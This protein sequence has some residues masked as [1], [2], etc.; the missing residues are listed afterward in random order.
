MPPRPGPDIK[1]IP[2]V[3]QPKPPR[4]HPIHI[5]GTPLPSVHHKPV[6]PPP[7]AKI[8]EEPQAK[9]SRT[10]DPGAPPKTRDHRKIAHA[11][12]RPRRP[13]ATE[14]RGHEADARVCSRPLPPHRSGGHATP[15]FREPDAVGLVV[16]APLPSFPAIQRSPHT[17]YFHTFD[18]FYLFIKIFFSLPFTQISLQHP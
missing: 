18:I 3:R 2:R 6:R 1:I 5:T 7:L 11:T 8:P 17:P 4:E 13:A 16:V 12:D 9:P 10:P 14:G 15:G